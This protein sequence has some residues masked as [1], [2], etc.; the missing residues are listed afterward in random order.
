M[1]SYNNYKY[2]IKL[3]DS[4][5]YFEVKSEK[6]RKYKDQLVDYKNLIFDN[7]F[8]YHRWKIKKKPKCGGTLE[9]YPNNTFDRFIGDGNSFTLFDLL[10]K[11]ASQN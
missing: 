9:I 3:Y 8:P 6:S 1:D 5:S 11:K 4:V 7:F 2:R 10:N